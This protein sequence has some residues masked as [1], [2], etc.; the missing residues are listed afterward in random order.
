MTVTV[1]LYAGLARYLP[2]GAQNRRAPLVLAEG[3]TVL[4]AMRQ[5]GM[6]EDLPCISVVNGNRAMPETAL[7]EGETLALFPPLA[8]GTTSN[9][10]L[11]MDRGVALHRGDIV[12]SDAG[13]PAAGAA[14]TSTCA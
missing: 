9:P 1:A 5:L 14:G 11:S 3:A 2:P 4:D 7:Q 12:P 6:P 13:L 8:G 10:L